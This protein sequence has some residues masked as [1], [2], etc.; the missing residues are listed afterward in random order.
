MKKQNSL[1][2]PA[3]VKAKAFTLIELLV[4]IAIIAILA[5]ILLP[6]LNSARER[7]RAA[8]CISNCKQI[9]GAL[10]MYAGDNDDYFPVLSTTW[11]SQPY[12][13]DGLSALQLLLPISRWIKLFP[14]GCFIVPVWCL[15]PR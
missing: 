15:I 8:S 11:S 13:S 9:S 14:A 1:P 10:S 5:A 7:G 2:L 6:A 4:V 3:G 12:A